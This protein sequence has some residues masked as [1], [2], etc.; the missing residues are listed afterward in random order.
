MLSRLKTHL[1][2][3]TAT[4]LAP[5]LCTCVAMT[6]FL[7]A[8]IVLRKLDN[9]YERYQYHPRHWHRWKLV[10]AFHY[11]MRG[12][13]VRSK[14]PRPRI[15]KMKHLEAIVERDW[16][17]LITKSPD[18]IK[19][20][21][22]NDG[23]A[24]IVALVQAFWLVAQV[25]G[26][27]VNRLPV[28]PLEI[29]AVAYVTCTAF[30]YLLWLEKPQ[31]VN[32][33]EVV[34]PRFGE[35]FRSPPASL[36]PA[37]GWKEQLPNLN[38][39]LEGWQKGVMAFTFLGIASLFGGLH[40]LAWN[41]EFPTYEEQMLWRI[42]CIGMIGMFPFLLVPLLPHPFSLPSRSLAHSDILSSPPPTLLHHPPRL[43]NQRHSVLPYQHPRFH[44]PRPHDCVRAVPE[45]QYARDFL[46]LEEC[47]RR[48]VQ[49]RAV[50]GGAAALVRGRGGVYM[51]FWLL[52]GMAW[53][54]GGWWEVWAGWSIYLHLC[55]CRGCRLDGWG[56][57]TSHLLAGWAV[58]AMID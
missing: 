5:E 37:G 17:R 55:I 21:S 56:Y 25:I 15:L 46:L 43:G 7:E 32:T 44:L 57:L 4:M 27:I 28:S 12:F 19:D 23:L 54:K 49:E 41:Y 2:W 53:R 16:L 35:L 34:D 45:L 33:A 58:Y 40:C 39:G 11:N 48:A 10:N 51:E 6:Q 14:W 26:R 18:A 9:L 42:S 30:T 31:D 52:G 50:D 38:R 8:L 47:T 36:E 3:M 20:L 22:K 24:K 29:S 13:V 1:G